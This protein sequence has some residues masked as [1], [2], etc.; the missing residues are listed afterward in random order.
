MCCLSSD[1]IYLFLWVDNSASS[2]IVGK[3]LVDFFDMLVILSASLLPIKSP[4][5]SAVFWIAH[6]DAV[7]IAF[8]ADFLVV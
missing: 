3:F 2:S 1:D 7:F 4:V 6:C 8:V 5:A